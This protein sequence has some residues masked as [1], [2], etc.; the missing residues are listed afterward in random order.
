MSFSVFIFLFK[1]KINKNIEID[2]NIGKRLHNFV[3]G[4]GILRMIIILFNGS[5]IMYGCGILIMV[6]I[7]LLDSRAFPINMPTHNTSIGYGKNCEKLCDP[8]LF[9]NP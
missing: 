7:P 8:R 3:Y 9:E 5:E 2:F 4:C 1:I 6:I